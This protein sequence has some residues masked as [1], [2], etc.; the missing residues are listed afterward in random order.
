M[1][2][3]Y[4]FS[5]IQILGFA[6]VLLRA[7]G[8]IISMP[9]IGVSNVP[10]QVKVLFSLC[11]AFIIFPAVGWE[12]LD[13]SLSDMS[14]VMLAIKEVFVGLT[15][16][17]LGRVFFMAVAMAGQV[18][19]VTMGVSSAQLFNPTF[20][21][22]M[23][24]FDQLFVIIATLLFFALNGHHIFIGGVVETFKL[25][26]ITRMD[27]NIQA[28][29]AVGPIAQ[30]TMVAAVKMAS[31]IIVT[32]LFTN[33]AMGL[34]GRAVPQINILITSLPVNVLAG[35]GVLFLSLPL[36]IW[37]MRDLLNTTA[38]QVFSL[39]KNL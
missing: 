24:T 7:I 21:E 11:L 29:A 13:V 8:F 23:G 35:L 5:E 31:P 37:E 34:V 18:I 19:S 17:F 22:S 1:A 10:V 27:L 16:G 36:M 15:F 2:S 39:L 12:K 30:A 20:N 28:Y 4:D 32:I 9:V 3:I 38:L 14:I 6:L 33:I 25:I 26:P